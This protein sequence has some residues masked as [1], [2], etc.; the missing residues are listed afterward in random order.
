MKKRQFASFV[1]ELIE[2]NLLFCLKCSNV[3]E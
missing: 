1:L 3:K 2:A